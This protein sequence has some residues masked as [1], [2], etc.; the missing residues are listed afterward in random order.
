MLLLLP[1]PLLLPLSVVAVCV[2][3][4]LLLGPYLN[5]YP[6]CSPDHIARVASSSAGTLPRSLYVSPGARSSSVTPT[7]ASSSCRW[8]LTLM[9]LTVD[10]SRARARRS[11]QTSVMAM[12]LSTAEGLR[13][14]GRRKDDAQLVKAGD[15]IEW[16]VKQLLSNGA[17]LTYDLVGEEKAAPMSS[18]TSALIEIM[19]SQFSN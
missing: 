3:G 18:V 1:L 14:L 13:W 2:R 11:R 16:A 19:G 12:F 7:L 17:P 6:L 5:E 10:R 4:L 15:A 8:P 9:N